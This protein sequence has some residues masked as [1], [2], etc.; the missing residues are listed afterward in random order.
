MKSGKGFHESCNAVFVSAYRKEL[1]RTKH[2]SKDE[3]DQE[4]P[5]HFWEYR[6]NPWFLTLAV[7]VFRRDPQLAPNVADVMTDKE[8]LRFASEV[9]AN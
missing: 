9:V 2:M 1:M 6:K 4:L 7:K 5:P 8:C 3:A